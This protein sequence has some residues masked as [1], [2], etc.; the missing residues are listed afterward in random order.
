ML[1]RKRLSNL[2]RDESGAALVA[3]IGIFAVTVILSMIV[4]SAT[5]NAIGFTSA[6]RASVQ[7]QASAESGIAA[8]LAGL[9]VADDCTSKSGV[10]SSAEGASPSYSATVW[11]QDDLGSWVKGCPQASTTTIRIISSGNAD[12][13]G[14]AGNSGGDGRIVEAVYGIG[15]VEE[16]GSA[17]YIYQDGQVNAFS[18]IG[19]GTS[20]D[21]RIL[22]GDFACT[23]GSVIEGSIIVAHGNANLSNTCIVQGSVHASGS[24]IVNN[25]VQVYGD[26]IASGGGGTVG[27][28]AVISGNMYVNGAIQVQG[29]IKGSLEATGSV[30]V[31]GNG[32]IKGNLT[33]GGAVRIDTRVDGNVTTP[34]SAAT[35]IVPGGLRVGGALTVGGDIGTWGYDGNKPSAGAT[36]NA[37]KAWYLNDKGYVVGEILYKQVG[38]V[39]PVPRDAPTVADWV[40]FGYNFTDWSNAGFVQELVWPDEGGCQLG[41]WDSDNP[42][43]KLYAFYQQLKSLT[44][45]T[46]VDARKCAVVDFCNCGN[47]DFQLKTDVAFISR[48]FSIGKLKLTSQDG[49]DH[50]A[51]FLVPDGEPSTPG[52]HCNHGAGDVKIYGASIVGEHVAATVYTPCTISINN[53]SLWRG[54]FYS[55]Q[56]TVSAGDTLTYVPVG[57]PG[58]DLDGGSGAGSGT[59]SDIFGGL[60]SSRNRA[61]T[62]E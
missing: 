14:I 42:A 9:Q 16:S 30:T 33:A 53:K 26:V 54:Q 17:I 20:G 3:V 60:V 35:T 7:S 34:S 57:I 62:G 13:P 39:A 36:E 2:R 27:S 11:R 61:D 24:V 46:V 22:N 44:V 41:S 6:T 8:A 21:I 5:I 38:L 43:G 23:T 18:I 37:K 19:T 48:G 40:D 15:A 25:S 58:T 51:W 12:S 31:N 49:T 50:K 29:V 1:L 56:F 4:S 28:A 10:Y 47:I 59:P 45:P 55:G 52:R 32:W